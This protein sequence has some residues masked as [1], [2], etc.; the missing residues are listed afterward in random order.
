MEEGVEEEE[1]EEEKEEG[2][3]TAVDPPTDRTPDPNNTCRVRNDNNIQLSLAN[4]FV[5]Y[6]ACTSPP[7]LYLSLLSNQE[8]HP[9]R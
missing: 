5:E 9:V 2:C 4:W 8:E 3:L 7:D 6:P 1:K